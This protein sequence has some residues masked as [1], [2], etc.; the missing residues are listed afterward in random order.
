M[1]K[2]IDSILKNNTWTLVDKPEN[3]NVVFIIG[4]ILLY[5]DQFKNPI[6]TKTFLL[7]KHFSQKYSADYNEAYAFVASVSK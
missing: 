3:K 7:A 6:L 1:I 5:I 2:E 4:G